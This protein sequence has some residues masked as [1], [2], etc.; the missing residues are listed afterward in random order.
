MGDISP[1]FN[2]SEFA[3]RCQ[4]G[5]ASVD[6]ELLTVL[7][8][9]RAYFADRYPDKL[10]T[11]KITS[12]NRCKDYNDTIPNSSANSQHTKG[13][14]ADIQVRNVDAAEV[15][16]YLINRYPGKYGIGSYPSAK[17]THIDV[18]EGPARW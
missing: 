10:I 13:L 1:N 3:C 4:C 15:Y 5:F 16:E 17:F 14:A 9:L 18:R 2:R 6:I 8:E 11:V 12:G 7:E